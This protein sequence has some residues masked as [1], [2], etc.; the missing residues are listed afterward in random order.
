MFKTDDFSYSLPKKF[1]AQ[2]PVVPRD[3]SKLMVFDTV[4]DQVLHKKFFEIEDFLR[5]GDVIVVNVSKV[6]PARIIFENDGKKRELFLLKK[7]SGN[8]YQVLVK[9][10]KIFKIGALFELNKE[11]SFEVKEIL[12]DG[13]RVVKFYMKNG[14]LDFDQVLPTV[15]QVPFPPY[16]TETKAN[17]DQ[18]QTV[19]AK[20]AGSV[21]APTAGLHFT[22]ELIAKLKQKG[23]LFE[24][25]ILHVNRGTF[26]PVK[27][28][29]IKD[30]KMHS[31]SFVLSEQTAVRLNKAKQNGQRIIAVGT[32]SVRVLE[33]CYNEID[34]FVGQESDTDIFIY[35]GRYKWKAVDALITNYHL[36]KSTL[37]MLVASFLENKSVENPVERLFEL[38]EIAKKEHYRFFS[39]GDA[40]FIF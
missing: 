17:P 19:Y 27:A 1:I 18:Y 38:Y 15:G 23:V 33:T 20:L 11:I 5:E 35:P 22:D 29:F 14:I 25:V 28:E 4:K 10:G 7:I 12:E 37:L 8:E 40:M 26:L 39:F 2:N 6:I 36:P 9:P 31:E 3:K 34:G 21:A 13:S 30:H 16:V 32:T 24:E